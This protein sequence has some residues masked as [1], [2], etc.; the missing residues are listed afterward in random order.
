[1]PCHK[2]ELVSDAPISDCRASWLPR[3]PLFRFQERI[4]RQRQAHRKCE[5]DRRVQHVFLKRVDNAVF[6]FE[7]F[8]QITLMSRF[9]RTG[10]G[11]PRFVTFSMARPTHSVVVT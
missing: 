6:H 3:F 5:L 1:M 4:S 7:S 2:P 10:V 11:K 9:S 8:A